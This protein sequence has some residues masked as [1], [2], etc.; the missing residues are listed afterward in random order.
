M[1]RAISVVVAVLSLFICGCGGSN[2]RLNRYAEIRNDAA[3]IA[4]FPTFGIASDEKMEKICE[5]AIL[6]NF[7]AMPGSEAARAVG[8][9][10][11]VRPAWEKAIKLMMDDKKV[12][13][14]PTFAELLSRVGQ[15]V[16]V[17]AIIVSV[18]VGSPSDYDDKKNIRFECGLFDLR[19]KNYV[20]IARTV[21]K[22]GLVP[23]PLE[24]FVSN[25]FSAM[26]SKVSEKTEK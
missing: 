16:G 6:A 22:K 2:V 14:D 3:T 12:V 24:A 18:V 11:K 15:T 21:D 25:A 19:D 26:K 13:I 17:D 9:Y 5:K 20:W 7:R 23:V 4:V 1:V 10:D 8:I